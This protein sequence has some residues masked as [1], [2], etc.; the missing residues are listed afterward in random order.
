MIDTHVNLHHE[1]YNDDLEEVINRAN[2]ANIDGM[3]SICD[4]ME[5]GEKILSIVENREKFWMSIGAHP[6]EAKDHIN[7]SIEDL[8]NFAKHKKVIGIGETG[9]DF[10][11]DLSPR[12]VQIDVFETHIKASQNLQ[13]PLIVHTR[14]A[15]VETAN[16]LTKAMKEQEFPLLMHCYTSGEELLKNMLDVNAYVSISG[17]ATFKNANDVRDN[18]QYIPNN[19]LLVETDCPYLAPI[20]KRGQRNEPAFINYLV[21]YL[22]QFLAKD[23]NQLKLEL[24]ENFYNL[25]KKA[26]L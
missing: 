17:I 11:Y 7:L 8:C 18:I 21:E 13:L 3:L 26:K 15:D 4:R 22:A 5:N 23:L 25:F 9:L 20:P 2:L 12:N 10:H 6:H 1:K 24:D 14:L 16:I 19:R